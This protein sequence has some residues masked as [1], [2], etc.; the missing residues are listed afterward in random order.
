M[1]VFW[2]PRVCPIEMLPTIFI[3]TQQ[4]SYVI[5]SKYTKFVNSL[6]QIKN[7]LRHK[8]KLLPARLNRF[9]IFHIWDAAIRFTDVL[10]LP[11]NSKPSQNGPQYCKTEFLTN[12]MSYPYSMIL[13]L[14]ILYHLRVVYHLNVNYIDLHCQIFD[15]VRTASQ[16]GFFGWVG[17]GWV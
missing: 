1:A 6:S 11:N 9:Q 2:K 5:S 8:M 3:K 7:K 12:C 17:G 14:S 4:V 16:K 13:K 15:L 10:N